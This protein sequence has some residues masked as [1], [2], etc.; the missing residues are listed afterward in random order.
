MGHCKVLRATRQALFDLMGPG[1]WERELKELDDGDLMTPD[2][3]EIS[4]ENPNKEIGLD[5]RLLSK[6]QRITLERGL[7]EVGAWFRGSGQ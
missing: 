2:G 4:I 7:G 5:G 1:D 6:K 3:T